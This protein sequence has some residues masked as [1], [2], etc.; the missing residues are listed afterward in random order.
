MAGTACPDF[1]YRE[2]NLNVVLTPARLFD[3]EPAEKGCKYYYGVL[4]GF[5]KV[6]CWFMTGQWFRVFISL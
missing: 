5:A 6:F 3:G 2:P 4:M 1:N